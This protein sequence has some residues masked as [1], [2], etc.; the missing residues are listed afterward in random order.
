M[1]LLW[2]VEKVEGKSLSLLPLAA[3]LR[4]RMLLTNFQNGVRHA[5]GLLDL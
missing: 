5:V 3:S 1:A 2:K 4:R